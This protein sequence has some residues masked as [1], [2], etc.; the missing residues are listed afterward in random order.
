MFTTL[1]LSDS[2]VALFSTA[3]KEMGNG[4]GTH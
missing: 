1:V 2:V 3:A 4:H